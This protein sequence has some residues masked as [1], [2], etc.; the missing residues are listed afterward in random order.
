M[1]SFASL[2]LG[3]YQMD[4]TH[5]SA[6]SCPWLLSHTWL[7]LTNTEE[8]LGHHA[9]MHRGATQGLPLMLMRH[10]SQLYVENNQTKLQNCQ[11]CSSW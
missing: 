3:K 9:S 5:G 8:A 1:P 4:D 6:P 2:L 11:T 7:I 10:I